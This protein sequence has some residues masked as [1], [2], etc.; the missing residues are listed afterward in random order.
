MSIPWRGLKPLRDLHVHQ[1]FG[2]AFGDAYGQLTEW[3]IHWTKTLPQGA[4]PRGEGSVMASTS[5]H[6]WSLHRKG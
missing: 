1:T 4:K 5:Q 2:A 6:D 3:C